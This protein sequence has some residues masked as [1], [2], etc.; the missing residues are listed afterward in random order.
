RPFIAA[1]KTS[2]PF[3]LAIYCRM[4]NQVK[5]V[6]GLQ[7]L[8]QSI[9]T[10]LSHTEIASTIVNAPVTSQIFG[11]HTGFYPVVYG[12]SVG[13][14]LEWEDAKSE[15]TGQVPCCFKHVETF[16]DALTFMLTKG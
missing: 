15:V 14:Y 9:N 6:S 10:S 13:I 5:E 2:P 1:S 3:P 16:V 7:G 11:K 4:E 8:I 12:G